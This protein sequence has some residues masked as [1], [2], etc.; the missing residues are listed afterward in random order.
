MTD[1]NMDRQTNKQSNIQTIKIGTDRQ[2]DRKFKGT[3]IGTDRQTKLRTNGQTRIQTAR[4]I[5]GQTD[6]NRD[7]QTDRQQLRTDGRA[8]GWRTHVALATTVHNKNI[9]MTHDLR[10]IHS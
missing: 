10:H 8:D 9:R 2:T 7:K 5:D 4:Q 3:K 1:T 6:K